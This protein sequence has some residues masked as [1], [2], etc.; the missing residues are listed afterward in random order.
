MRSGNCP[1]LGFPEG[2]EGRSAP[3]CG[4]KKV[5]AVHYAFETRKISGSI[6]P[7]F[8]VVGMQN[9]GLYRA[10]IGARR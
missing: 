5:P 7:K 1:F 9:N 8:G 2:D 4:L 3:I 6:L 10:E